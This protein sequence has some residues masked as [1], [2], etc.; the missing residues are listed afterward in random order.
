MP[1]SKLGLSDPLLRAIAD[2]GYSTPSNSIA[3]YSCCLNG[4]DLLAARKQVPVKPPALRYHLASFIQH[5]YGANRPIRSV[6]INANT[7]NLLHK[8]VSQ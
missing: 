3:G 5:A 1:F 7:A 2:A 6:N 8:S 4:H